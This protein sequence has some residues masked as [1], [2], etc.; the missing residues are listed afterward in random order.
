MI[1]INY[2]SDKPV[3]R[4]PS[5]CI[6]RQIRFFRQP[7]FGEVFVRVK[8]L[9]KTADIQR[10]SRPPRICVGLSVIFQLS[11]YANWRASIE[12]CVVCFGGKTTCCRVGHREQVPAGRINRRCDVIMTSESPRVSVRARA[13]AIEAH[14]SPPA[15]DSPTQASEKRRV[16]DGELFLRCRPQPPRRVSLDTVQELTQHTPQV[17]PVAATCQRGDVTAPFG[18][19]IFSPSPL[20]D[21]LTALEKI[22]DEFAD[23]EDNPSSKAP[24]DDVF[25]E[26]ALRCHE[27]V[28]P[29]FD[30]PPLYR[31]EL[32]FSPKVPQHGR[33]SSPSEELETVK[34][35]LAKLDFQKYKRRFSLDTAMEH[36]SPTPKMTGERFQDLFN[37]KPN[38]E[39]PFLLS[40]SF[41]FSNGEEHIYTEIK[42]TLDKKILTLPCQKTH[43]SQ[44]A[45]MAGSSC[46]SFFQLSESPGRSDSDVSTQRK[47]RKGATQLDSATRKCGPGT[48]RSLTYPPQKKGLADETSGDS[49]GIQ[50]LHTLPETRPDSGLLSDLSLDDGHLCPSEGDEAYP[51]VVDSVLHSPAQHYL[52]VPHKKKHHSDP[53]GDSTSPTSSETSFGDAK[54]S[55]RSEPQ[56]GDND[57]LKLVI[58]GR[59]YASGSLT[60][61]ATSSSH[62]LFPLEPRRYSKRRLRGPYGEMLEE[63]MRK[64]TERSK[65][66]LQPAM[67]LS[68]QSLDEASSPRNEPKRKVSANYPLLQPKELQNEPSVPIEPPLVLKEPSV[69]REHPVA[70]KEPAVVQKEPSV[71]KEVQKEHS[72]VQQEHSASKES[73]V[74]DKEAK[75]SPQQKAKRDS[76]TISS[77]DK[78]V[79]TRTHVVYEILETERSYVDSLQILVTK[80]MG[81]LKSSDYNGVVEGGIVDEI[82]FQVPEILSIH[83]VFLDALEKRCSTFEVKY[84]VGDLFM[85]AFTK[86]Q[87]IDTYTAFINN[88]KCAKDATKIAT[89]AKPAFARFL[90]HMSREHKGKLALD[91]LLIMPVQRIPRYE[92][93]LKELLKHTP[94]DHPDHHLLVQAQKEVHDLAVKIN[95]VEREAFQIEQMQQRVREIEHHIDGV[96]DLCVPDRAFLRHDVVTI[97]GGL[98]TKKERCLFLFSDILLITSIKR[99][100]VAMRK[101]SSVPST[102]SQSPFSVIDSNKYKLLTKFSIESMEI[103]KNT[104]VNLKKAMR[105]IATLEEDIQILNQVKDLIDKISSPHQN[106]EDVIRDLTNSVSKQMLEK[107]NNDYSL[108]SLEMT[109][110]TQERIE[111]LIIQ[112]TSPERRAVWSAAFNEAK[113][114]L[115]RRPP[116]ELKKAMPIRKTRAGLQ[117]TCATATG[118]NQEGMREVWVC[119]SDGYVGQVCVLSLS[120][121]PTV[122][123]CNGVCNARILTI[124]SVPATCTLA[125]DR[126]KWNPLS[127]PSADNSSGVNIEIQEVKVDCSENFANNGNIQLDSESSD[128]EDETESADEEK[129]DCRKRGNSIPREDAH[130]EIYLKQP[131][132][133]LGTED[134]CVH[135]YNCNDN[136]RTK[137]NK[138][139]MQHSAAIQCII[140]L[141]NRVFAST[142]NGEVHVYTKETE[143]GWAGCE[144]YKIVIGSSSAPVPIM[145]AVAGKIWCGCLNFIHV[146]NTGALR[147]EHSFP[148]S[149]DTS[150]YVLTMVTSGLGVWI[151]VTPSAVVRLF[152]ATN[153]EPL[154][155][156]NVAPTVAKILSAATDDIIKQHKSACL[157]VT[158]MLACKDLLWIGTSAG[159]ILTLPLPH[160]TSSTLSVDIMPP[161]TGLPHGHTG[162]VRFLTSVELS[163][164]STLDSTSSNKH[165]SRPSKSKESASGRRT[166][167]T[168]TATATAGSKILVISG[169]DGYEDFEMSGL[170]DQ[171]GHDDSTNHLL[172]WHV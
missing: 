82:F 30:E 157:R 80:Y 18:P 159:V 160:L 65:S 54:G 64:S 146:I 93:L 114:K 55:S 154:I 79:D 43:A 86:Q 4:P 40:R 41:S 69:Q 122:L 167:T 91:A 148:V 32:V 142:A 44:P 37:W 90:E 123:S 24:R 107:Q 58:D 109:I 102:S 17:S 119:N 117:F 66:F 11:F 51:D 20:D 168:T 71:Q 39:K 137:K 92:L 73:S 99:K 50:L 31:S 16:S 22:C 134:G 47:R 48:G 115:G 60:S 49:N 45:K 111:N 133:W 140:Y 67:F 172:L 124:A 104:D 171:A 163:S 100:S 151:T 169:G 126:S 61:G 106:L 96:V 27:Y 94:M 147:I 136:I 165:S 3:F 127:I 23:E 33:D 97:P 130:V 128:D 150:R 74:V 72:V 78:T 56:L 143:G 6:W 46:P 141:D 84:T 135:V 98:G 68:S 161:L 138:I 88:W 1:H 59:T 25:D 85:E 156:V 9:A 166:S 112:F 83:D 36:K 116:P 95:R 155:D 8:T 87:V 15:A 38:R 162:H 62:F 29:A 5:W 164:G 21:I 110:T 103:S 42:D 81:A 120:P 10:F 53:G 7:S 105:D 129:G 75:S 28:N 57:H 131:T 153:F 35:I 52:S 26:K 19:A 152:H 144:P 89:Q 13:R 108:I 118:Y 14:L 170:G 121:E 132:V 139:K 125:S 63:E 70:Q 158:A 101:P 77:Q 2:P 76:V 145:L 113:L 12:L 34:N 149:S